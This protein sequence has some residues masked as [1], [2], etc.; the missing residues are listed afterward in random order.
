[1]ISELKIKISKIFLNESRYFVRLPTPLAKLLKLSAG[2]KDFIEIKDA[3][4]K[5]EAITK[6]RDEIKNLV[7]NKIE[8]FENWIPSQEATSKSIKELNALKSF[9]NRIENTDYLDNIDFNVEEKATIR[10]ISFKELF[11]KYRDIAQKFV[12]F[13]KEEAEIGFSRIKDQEEILK[14]LNEVDKF[15]D[16]GIS[17]TGEFYAILK[18]FDWNDGHFY[19]EENEEWKDIYYM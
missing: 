14:D 2:T 9:K 17:E 5:E 10:E 1:M 15:Y 19:D 16:F 12:E 3:S 13:V 11:K 8:F 7:D 4:S 18:G 6:T